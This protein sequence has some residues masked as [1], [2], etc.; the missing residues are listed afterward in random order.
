MSTTPLLTLALLHDG[1]PGGFS[2]T[3]W[4]IHP[5]VALGCALFIG[6]YFWAT[7]PLAR[8]RGWSG[9]RQ[10][11]ETGFFL[12]GVAVL[13]LALNGPLHDLSDYYLFS[14]HMVQH[15]LLM[16]VFPAL[17]LLGLPAYVL[18]PLLTG[19]GR[20]RLARTLTHPATAFVV[21]NVVLIGWHFPALYNWALVNHDVH[22]AQH[23]LFIGA[24]TLMWWPIVDPLPELAR[25]GSLLKMLYIFAFGI[26]MS[27]VSAFI[28]MASGAVYPWYIEAPRLFGLTAL[29]D[30]QLGGLIMWIPGM[31]I[32]WSVVSVIFL[33]YSARE[34]RDEPLEEGVPREWVRAG[35]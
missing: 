6:L 32:Y 33:R 35:A 26:P 30:Q 23:L 29:E 4:E 16:M 5:S 8:R 9:S 20:E 19:G 12:A 3:R 10:T 31:L 15:M 21:Y 1:Q 14:A 22:V 17:L 18:R 24:A 13:F 25:M 27:V 34:E 28:T 11:H 7:G 2:W